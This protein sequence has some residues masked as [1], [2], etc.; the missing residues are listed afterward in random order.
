MHWLIE[1]DSENSLSWISNGIVIYDLRTSLTILIVF[2]SKKLAKK[3]DFNFHFTR[4]SICIKYLLE[5]NYWQA[6][7]LEDKNQY[8]D[9]TVK[10]NKKKIKNKLFPDCCILSDHFRSSDHLRSSDLQRSSNS[11][12]YS[13]LLLELQVLLKH[14]KKQ[15]VFF[16][17]NYCLYVYLST[18]KCLKILN[19]TEKPWKFNV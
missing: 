12:S 8:F 18:K 13:V 16:L 17:Q 6:L 14:S 9:K 15:L 5:E 19:K 11:L 10:S 2:N 4:A 7:S 1:K 3:K